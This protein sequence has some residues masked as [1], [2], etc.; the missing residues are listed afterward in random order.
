MEYQIEMGM[1]SEGKLTATVRVE[2]QEPIVVTFA[3]RDKVQKVAL[4]EGKWESSLLFIARD[5]NSYVARL[6]K[7]DAEMLSRLALHGVGQKLGDRYAQ[8]EAHEA[9]DAV[10]AGDEALI[11]GEWNTRGAG[12]ESYLFRALCELYE[13][14]QTPEQIKTILD[15][16]KP[17]EK[18]ALEATAEVAEIINRLRPQKDVTDILAKFGA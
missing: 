4:N 2:G 3:D 8:L 16:L 17:A 18:R 13:G 6:Q 10:R 15:G 14:I 12:R 1:T 5:G 9:L 7:Y 11:A